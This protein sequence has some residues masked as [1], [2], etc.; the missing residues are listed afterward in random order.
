MKSCFGGEGTERGPRPPGSSF[1][2]AR[3]AGQLAGRKRMG[4]IDAGS[5][6]GVGSASILTTFLNWNLLLQFVL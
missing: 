5:T 1:C 3:D 6:D 4:R 2:M